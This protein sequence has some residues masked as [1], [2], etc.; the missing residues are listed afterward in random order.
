VDNIAFF[1]AQGYNFAENHEKATLDEKEQ[2]P[3]LQ[4][5]P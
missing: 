4:I 3:L 5:F 1:V 2:Q